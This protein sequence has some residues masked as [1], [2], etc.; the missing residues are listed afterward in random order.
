[1]DVSLI[2]SG[3]GSSAYPA[4]GIEEKSFQKTG[5]SSS[6]TTANQEL[7]KEEEREVTELKKKDREVKA[8]ESAHVAAGGRY[9]RGG[10]RYEYETGPDGR[11]Y[12]VGGEVAIDTSP[13]SGNPRA[14]IQKMRV[15]KAA[16]LAPAQPSSADRAIAVK[17]AAEAS[18][19]QAELTKEQ[20]A[21]AQGKAVPEADS[22]TMKNTGF[23]QGL[24]KI[25]EKNNSYY[26]VNNPSVSNIS[27][28]IMA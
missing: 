26:A 13:V 21:A 7:S 25:T 8:H 28:D 4:Y 22:N 11:R 27:I 24:P 1:M 5:S 15:V 3:W 6:N 2:S 9:I 16:A 19:A 17:A 14:T 20:V 12:A 23:E 18:K 10:A